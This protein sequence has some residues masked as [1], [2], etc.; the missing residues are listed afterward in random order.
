MADAA[1]SRPAQV[2]KAIGGCRL[3]VAACGMTVFIP[4]GTVGI[5]VSMLSLLPTFAWLVLLAGRFLRFGR[6]CS[7]R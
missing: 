7:M 1:T 3:F 6:M 5:Y 2:A 4:A